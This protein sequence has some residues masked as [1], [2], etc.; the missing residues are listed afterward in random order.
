MT[1]R[2]AKTVIGLV[3]TLLLT[4]CGERFE[5]RR[6]KDTQGREHECIVY[7]RGYKGGISCDWGQP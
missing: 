6:I 1:G 7:H 3:L 2:A 4:G 5:A